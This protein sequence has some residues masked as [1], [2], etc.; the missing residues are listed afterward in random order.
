MK[1]HRVHA[2]G[3]LSPAT[4]KSEYY[5]V[6]SGEGVPQKGMTD[7]VFG[8][9]QHGYEARLASRVRAKGYWL[10]RGVC[11]CLLYHRTSTIV[12]YW[13]RGERVAAGR[14][15][16]GNKQQTKANEDFA[17]VKAEGSCPAQLHPLDMRFRRYC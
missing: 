11:S 8:S 16:A 3:F 2:F 12:Y 15:R 1:I 17:F 6:E 14:W 10:A 13:S 9:I 7:S 5:A 4:A